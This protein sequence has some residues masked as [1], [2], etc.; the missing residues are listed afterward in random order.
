MNGWKS[1]LRGVVGLLLCAIAFAVTA[2]NTV[3]KVALVIGNRDYAD[4]KGDLKNTLRDAEL[5]AQSLK[6]LGFAVTERTNLGRSQMLAEVADF[7]E[8]IPPGATALIYYAGHG[9]QVGGNSYLVPV[10]MEITSEQTVPIKAYPVNTVL[11]RLS[12]SQSAVNIVVVDACRAN[13]FQPRN[14]VRYRNFA[15]LGLAAVQ[16][17]R[18]TL[19]AYSTEPGQL[20]ADGK[21]SNSIY[22]ATLAKVIL[23]PKPG[24][25]RDL[26]QDREPGTQETLDDQ[27]PWYNTSLTDNY[28]FLPPEG[29]TVVAGKSL[30]MADAGRGETGMR[31]GVDAPNAESVA[32]YNNLHQE[33]MGPA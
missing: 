7:S 18:G 2:G 23:E 1:L 6:K 33:R 19:I 20:A 9:M 14:P 22:T 31:R 27:I 12:A 3:E 17:P 28:Y 29:V 11:E 16:A 21:E 15:D 13:P 26:Q 4:R 8:R 24:A 5:M 32:S 25:P 30:R 10:D